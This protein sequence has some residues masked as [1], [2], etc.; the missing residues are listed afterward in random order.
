MGKNKQQT[1]NKC[2]REEREGTKKVCNF[3]AWITYPNITRQKQ[4][5]LKCVS[6][7]SD[8]KDNLR[9]HKKYFNK[10]ASTCKLIYK[11][12]IIL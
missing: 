6:C 8:I 10:P 4:H 7:T 3:C 1:I 5:L 12:I 9:R 2:F 11:Y